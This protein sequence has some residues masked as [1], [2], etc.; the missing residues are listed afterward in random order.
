MHAF[1]A[2]GFVKGLTRAAFEIPSLEHEP[3]DNDETRH[4]T[5][6][7]DDIIFA[8]NVFRLPTS[9]Q[10]RRIVVQV[11]G[12]KAQQGTGNE[13]VVRSDQLTRAAA[14]STYFEEATAM[15]GRG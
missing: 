7:Y 14:L 6:N 9:Q 13:P 3:G 2:G 8:S 4:L 10:Q 5:A 12:F 11:K 1:T 15:A